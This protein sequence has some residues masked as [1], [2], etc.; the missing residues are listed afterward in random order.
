M[1][2]RN[3][4]TGNLEEVYVKAL[5]SLPVGTIL[6]F[7]TTS[8]SN[9][10]IGYMFC[11]GSA[12]SRTT[13]AELFALIGTSYGTGDGSTTFNLP[14]YKGRVPVGRDS[15]QTEFDTIGETGGSKYLQEHKHSIYWGATTGGTGDSVMMGANRIGA[16]S[17]Q[18]TNAGT[19]NSGNL[20]PYIVTNYI[21]K[22]SQTRALA[23]KTVNAF[24]NST[25][26]A[27]CCDYVN[28]CNTYSTDETFTGKYWIDGKP[29]YRKVITGTTPSTS[30]YGSTTVGISNLDTM[31]SILGVID[32]S[33]GYRVFMP[34][35]N[36]DFDCAYRDA[37][38]AFIV[39]PVA[40]NYMSSS[41]RVAF[42]YT[43]SS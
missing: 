41:F 11:D 7:P 25:T 31:T 23:G 22:V 34:L 8:S 3:P 14:N 43:K 19:G 1:K 4:S 10:P 9:L 30:T 15:T 38:D 39:H 33:D 35:N 6:E 27:Y 37:S 26:D 24:S 16:T 2:A 36:S 12:I 5:D 28:D 32:R 20:Q 40:S 13:Y 42:E 21:I 18:V 29:I 17:D